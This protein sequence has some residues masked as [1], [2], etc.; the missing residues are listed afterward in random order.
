MRAIDY[1]YYLMYQYLIL[2]ESNRG[3]GELFS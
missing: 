1:Q 2:A 3:E